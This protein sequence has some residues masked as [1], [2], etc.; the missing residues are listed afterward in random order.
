MQLP[1]FTRVLFCLAFT[2]A[3]IIPVSLSATPPSAYSALLAY[4]HDNLSTR[5]D[6]WCSECMDLCYGPLV[7]IANPIALQEVILNYLLSLKAQRGGI[8]R[9]MCPQICT[10]GFQDVLDVYRMNNARKLQGEDRLGVVGLTPESSARA[11]NEAVAYARRRLTCTNKHRSGMPKKGPLTPSSS[12]DLKGSSSSQGRSKA[13]TESPR[14][15]VEKPLP[16]RVRSQ[17][18]NPSRSDDLKQ[19]IRIFPSPSNSDG[20][21]GDGGMRNGNG[22]AEDRQRTSSQREPAVLGPSKDG[23][24]ITSSLARF[25]DDARRPIQ[26]PIDPFISQVKTRFSGLESTLT[27]KGFDLRDMSGWSICMTRCLG[28]T[29]LATWPQISETFEACAVPQ[30]CGDAILQLEM[31]LPKIDVKQLVQKTVHDSLEQI[32]RTQEQYGDLAAAALA[33]MLVTAAAFTAVGLLF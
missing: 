10:D 25:F 18:V 28:K 22:G 20:G 26:S 19:L 3:T 27:Q 17:I 1:L 11:L 23:Y 16:E 29:A 32:Q 7:P 24:S 5:H 14:Q 15:D 31:S 9:K 30:G 21:G 13:Q 6:E 33:V 2:I 12:Q 4:F 8:K